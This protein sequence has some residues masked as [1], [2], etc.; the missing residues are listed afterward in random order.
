MVQQTIDTLARDDDS[1]H[2]WLPTI[3]RVAGTPTPPAAR[4]EAVLLESYKLLQEMATRAR[5]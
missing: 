2:S 5:K 3:T 4:A 1:I